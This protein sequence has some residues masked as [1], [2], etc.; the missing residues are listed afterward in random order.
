MNPVARREAEN[1][2]ENAYRNA[3]AKAQRFPEHVS[4]RCFPG[5]AYKMQGQKV[6]LS[7]SYEV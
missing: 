3:H 6:K 4:E 7:I 5:K 2:S 1:A